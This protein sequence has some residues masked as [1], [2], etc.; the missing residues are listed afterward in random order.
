MVSATVCRGLEKR[1]HRGGTARLEKTRTGGIMT[2]RLPMLAD[3]PMVKTWRPELDVV[4]MEE[5]EAWFRTYL[6][7]A[8]EHRMRI[9]MADGRAVGYVRLDLVNGKREISYLTA[10]QYRKRGYCVAMLRAALEVFGVTADQVVARIRYNND[11]SIHC[12][13]KL[14]IPT[15]LLK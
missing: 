6:L 3:A 12:A 8:Y 7:D 15:E 2:L 11:A 14:G 5:H 4:S 1:K 13:A 10:P 9:A